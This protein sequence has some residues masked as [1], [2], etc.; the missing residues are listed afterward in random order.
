M[1]VKFASPTSLRRQ[2]RATRK[3]REV[4]Q[5][6]F[7]IANEL[8]RPSRQTNT[9]LISFKVE[10]NMYHVCTHVSSVD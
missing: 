2:R 10:R 1:T 6:T 9:E 7:S 4:A 8:I 3:L 5:K